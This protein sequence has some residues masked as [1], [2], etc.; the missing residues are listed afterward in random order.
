MTALI[1]AIT[2]IITSTHNSKRAEMHAA[3]QSILQLILEDKVAVMNGEKPENFQAV[4]QEFDDYKK[5]G[6][7][8][9]VD[10]KVAEYEA[11][12]SNISLRGNNDHKK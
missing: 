6:G 2:T 11:W 9:Y 8:H 7:N 12:Y 4:E 1:P 5:N 10:R 3:R